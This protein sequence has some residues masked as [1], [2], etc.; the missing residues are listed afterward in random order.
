M[1]L[2]GACVLPPVWCDFNPLFGCLVKQV[3]YL[4]RAK[5]LVELSLLEQHYEEQQLTDR[6]F[7][8]E[9]ENQ[10]VGTKWNSLLFWGFYICFGVCRLLRPSRSARK[11]KRLAFV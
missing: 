4:E 2:V 9:Q 11:G 8:V 6:E 3:D 7:H 1:A 5:R 10:M